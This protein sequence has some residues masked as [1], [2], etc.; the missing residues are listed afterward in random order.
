[1]ISCFK[2]KFKVTSPMGYRTDPVTGEK[3]VYHKGLDLVALGE[4]KNVYAISD[5]VIDAVPYESLGFGRYVRQLLPDGRR[6]YYAHL[7]YDS[8]AVKAGQK[9]TKGDKLGVMGSTGKSTGAHTHLELRVKG[10]S[11]DS[12]DISEFTGI[13]N[14]RGTY[15][16]HPQTDIEFVQERCGFA[17]STMEYLS[18]YKYAVDLFA[19][20]RKAMEG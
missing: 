19:K 18:E 2:G 20:L 11:K 13:P 17:D 12:L 16:A 1:M 8:A 15:E 7:K 9:V 6:I 3:G 14:E 10:T 4:D 5:G